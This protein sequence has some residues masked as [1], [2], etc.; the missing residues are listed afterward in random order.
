MVKLYSLRVWPNGEFGL[1][2]Y[3]IGE[4]PSIRMGT[5]SPRPM[6]YSWTKSELH[7]YVGEMI[8]N[9]HEGSEVLSYL[10]FE[11]RCSLGGVCPLGSSDPSNSHKRPPRGSR[12]ITSYGKKMLRNGCYLLEKV[13]GVRAVG[14]ITCTIPVLPGDGQKHVCERWADILRVFMQW[15]HRRLKPHCPR[16]WVLG[17]TEVQALR[18]QREGGLP[19]HCHLVFVARTRKGYIVSKEEFRDAWKRAVLAHCPELA[20]YSFDA[21]TR[22]EQCRKSVASYLSKYMSKGNADN[23]IRNVEEGYKVP[24]SWWHGTGGFKQYIKKAIFYDAGEIA[25][26]VWAG[27]Y[28]KSNLFT[29]IRECTKEYDG[30]PYVVGVCGGMSST[31]Q[32]LIRAKRVGVLAQRLKMENVGGLT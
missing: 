18:M 8:R 19:L 6:L 23:V 20:D 12:G 16:P 28:R 25:A 21:S 22:V 13:R 32:A 29:W 4:R 2:R 9:G 17:C 31:L 15:L 24:S 7:S 11:Q 10:S 1:G 5:R 26:I 30:I 3:P 27:T 14:M